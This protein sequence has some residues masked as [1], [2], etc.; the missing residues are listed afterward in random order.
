MKSR[1][2]RVKWFREARYGMFVHWGIY[3]LLGRAEWVM[4]NEEIPKDEYRKLAAGFNPV[5]FDADHWAQVMEDSGMK[6]LVITAKHHDGFAMFKSHCSDYNIVDAT[7]F[8]RDPMAELA[9]A[10]GKR[11]IKLCF[12][13]SHVQDW[14]EH[15]VGWDYPKLGREGNNWHSISEDDAAT[16]AEYYERKCKPQ[17]RELLTQYGPTGLLWFDTPI[18]FTKEQ[19]LDLSSFIRGIQP[20]CLINGRILGKQLYPERIPDIDYE[21][22]GDNEV[23]PLPSGIDWEAPMTS[24]NG[25]GYR[26]P[27]TTEWK[28]KEL[29][30]RHLIRMSASGGNYLL[31]IGPSPEGELPEPGVERF[32]Y[33]GEWLRSNGESIYGTSG[34]PFGYD[35]EWGTATSKPGRVYLHVTGNP[36]GS[37]VMNG[38]ESKVETARFLSDQTSESLVL[39]ASFDE[40]L[41]SNRL[42]IALPASLP[43]PVDAVIALDIDGEVQVERPTSQLADGRISLPGALATIHKAHSSSTTEVQANGIIGGWFDADDWV[44]WEFKVI[45]PGDYIAA[46]VQRA[47]FWGKHKWDVGHRLTIEIAGTSLQVVTSDEGAIDGKGGHRTRATDCG[48]VTFSKAG[49]YNVKVK[50]HHI[51]GEHLWGL[52]LQSIELR[53]V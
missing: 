21:G 5:K 37:I 2:E 26:D 38:L 19:A 42:S 50:P 12:Y 45:M 49:I 24:C 14:Y 22:M 16:F 11:N 51:S 40:A 43:D 15:R 33:I 17:I 35:F 41:E 39:T 34:N 53:P 28:D 13:Y 7:P 44:E 29:L 3:S 18:F 6:Y 8:D 30:L 9:E 32:R 27:Q 31:N 20:D 1:E 4:H 47:D 48:A 36:S 10:C 52:R 25:W 46:L 23:P